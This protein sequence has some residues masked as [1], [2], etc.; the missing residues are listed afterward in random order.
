MIAQTENSKIELTGQLKNSYNRI[1]GQSKTTPTEQ[2]KTALNVLP[3]CTCI[4]F[5]YFYVT[6]KFTITEESKTALTYNMKQSV[7]S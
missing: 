1:T 6:Q 5:L 3:I 7:H 2:S 4:G